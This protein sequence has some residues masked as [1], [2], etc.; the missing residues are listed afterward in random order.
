M[1]YDD[2]IARER[3]IRVKLLTNSPAVQQTGFFRICLDCQEIC[4][5]HELLCPNC[6]SDRICEE[7]LDDIVSEILEGKRIRCLLRY[8]CLSQE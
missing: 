3:K 1:N 2:W 6:G 5:C 8:Q 7:K 4:L